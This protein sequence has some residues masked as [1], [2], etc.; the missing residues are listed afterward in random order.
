VVKTWRFTIKVQLKDGRYKAELYDI[1]YTFEQPAHSHKPFFRPTTHRLDVLFTDP[2]LYGKDGALKRGAPVNIA[3]WTREAF[4]AVLSDLQR[5]LSED[6]G[7]DD[8]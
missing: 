2:K 7:V 5:A 4:E 8:F 6:V 1:D 3:T